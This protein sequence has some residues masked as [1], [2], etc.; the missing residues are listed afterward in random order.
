MN[1]EGNINESW[2]Y[3]KSRVI[4]T[5]ELEGDWSSSAK[6]VLTNLSDQFKRLHILSTLDL[7]NQPNRTNTKTCKTRN[8]FS[9]QT[10]NSLSTCS[11]TQLPRTSRTC[12]ASRGPLATTTPAT[13]TSFKSAE[14]WGPVELETTCTE[15]ELNVF[16]S[17]LYDENELNVFRDLVE[18]V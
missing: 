16:F 11:W 12:T 1:Q 7:V 8:V 4:F 18:Y 3:A 17:L 14:R 2:S 6:Y 15:D 9:K 10:Y 5:A 13:V